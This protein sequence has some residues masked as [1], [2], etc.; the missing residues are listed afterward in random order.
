MLSASAPRLVVEVD[1][2]NRATDLPPEKLV[3]PPGQNYV[4]FTLHI[5]NATTDRP[6]N[7][8]RHGSYLGEPLTVEVPV[9][10]KD[11]FGPVH[12][13][14]TV[15][16]TAVCTPLCELLLGVDFQSIAA[17][18]SAEAIPIGGRVDLALYSNLVPSTAPVGD[19]T[20][21]WKWPQGQDISVPIVAN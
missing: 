13:V 21:H 15:G 3:A 19:I 7:F 2:A 18:V 11:A 17:A 12:V 16:G 8:N 20:V 1:V 4:T 9:A 14:T 5:V 6:A 10:D